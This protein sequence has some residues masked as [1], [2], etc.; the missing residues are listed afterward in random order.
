MDL[1]GRMANFF[2][3]SDSTMIGYM[4]VTAVT[5]SLLFYM[6]YKIG[7][8]VTVSD[9]DSTDSTPCAGPPAPACPHP[10]PGGTS[11]WQLL[12]GAMIRRLVTPASDRQ[13]FGTP[14][15]PTA[16]FGTPMYKDD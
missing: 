3:D 4:I 7:F 5:V 14:T 9:M 6:G 10:S 12:D 1:F 8:A 11:V 15:Q 13:R 16:R 2:G